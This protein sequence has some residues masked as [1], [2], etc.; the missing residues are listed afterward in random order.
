MHREPIIQ[1]LSKGDAQ[2][3][4]YPILWT[5][6]TTWSTLW[7]DDHFEPSGPGSLKSLLLPRGAE[8]L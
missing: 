5:R 6:G 1:Y 4:P 3:S 2:G 7:Q 8:G